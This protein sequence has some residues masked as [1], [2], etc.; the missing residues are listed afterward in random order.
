M[1]LQANRFKYLQHRSWEIEYR[2]ENRDRTNQ[3]N[4]AAQQASRACVLRLCIIQVVLN[5]V[6]AMRAPSTIK[7]VTNNV[8]SNIS[9]KY[10]I[11]TIVETVAGHDTNHLLQ[12]ER[13]VS[14]P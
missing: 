3:H 11:W 14:L 2:R 10:I 5:S 8:S 1:H 7:P 9:N 12:I 6:A 4:T 13:L